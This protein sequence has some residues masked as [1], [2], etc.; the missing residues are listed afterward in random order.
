MLIFGT[1]KKFGP[2]RDELMDCLALILQLLC[3]GQ[4]LSVY[5][6]ILC[7]KKDNGREDATNSYREAK[8]CH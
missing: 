6:E 2:V 3:V 5:L 4:I 7:Q 1:G 8:K